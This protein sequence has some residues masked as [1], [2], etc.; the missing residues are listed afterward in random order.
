MG[1][2]L[3]TP[4]HESMKKT[5]CFVRT[6]KSLLMIRFA[7]FLCCWFFNWGEWGGGPR[8]ARGVQNNAVILSHDI[9]ISYQVYLDRKPL[10]KSIAAPVV[11]RAN[12]AVSS[13]SLQLYD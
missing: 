13:V 12:T 1:A 10:T 11:L 6:N 2:H 5:V 8:A 4:Q 9:A 3:Q 7:W